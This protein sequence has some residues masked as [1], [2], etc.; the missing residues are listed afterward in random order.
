MNENIGAKGGHNDLRR[1]AI[2]KENKMKKQEEEELEELE[3]RVKKKQRYT[4]IRTLPIVITGGVIKTFFDNR[5]EEEK[6]KSRE[7]AEHGVELDKNREKVT[8][9]EVKKNKTI[10]VNV[11][12]S[13]NTVTEV[14]DISGDGEKIIV[15]PT[16]EKIVVEDN[17]D[18]DSIL[19][20]ITG[21]GE[22][23]SSGG[24]IKMGEKTKSYSENIEYNDEY[25]IR[26]MIR[27]VGKEV[28]FISNDLVERLQQIK[29][30][31]IM[32]EYERLF[33]EMRYELRKT[34]YEYDVIVDQNDYVIFS[35][36]AQGLLNR[37]S[38]MVDRIEKLK[39]QMIVEDLD[40]YD[41]H[42]L[43]VMIEDYLKQFRDN[44]IV[45]D[46]RESKL[47]IMISDRL[48]EL[49]NRRDKLNDDIEKKKEELELREIRLE[50]LRKEFYSVDKLNKE[51]ELFQE[52]QKKLIDEL[53]DKVKN[54]T[55][56]TQRTTYEM[57]AID[58]ATRRMMRLV[59]FQM[60]LPGPRFARGLATTG[61]AYLHF[62]NRIINPPLTEKK[63]NVVTVKDYSSEIENSLASIDDAK[64]LL[65]KTNIEIDKML[66]EIKDKYSD[67]FG[68]VR[69][70]DE[71]VSNLNRIKRDMSEKEYEMDQIKK[72]QELIL[73]KNNAKVKTIG[74]Y[75][76]N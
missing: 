61:A 55:T 14:R 51:L 48:E 62:L 19:D 24:N 70:C 1:T 57:Q 73:E 29:S 69:E 53:E 12:G 74:E 35:E 4:L 11:G 13:V 75:T 26:N 64:R 68:V 23:S 17:K 3:K 21:T 54:A 60:F 50:D 5:T 44:K 6:N 32:E 67:Y 30:K 66:A 76:V 8:G 33:K 7:V 16:G 15:S 2:I 42:F 18:K 22:R 31:R 43:Y 58:I 37:L 9:V 45:N 34:I 72:E 59:A 40:K 47:Y 28:D 46:I 27:T 39:S 20:L 65:G 36:E 52:E 71:L 41:D 10:K 63:Y 25:D 56:V 49:E 38:D